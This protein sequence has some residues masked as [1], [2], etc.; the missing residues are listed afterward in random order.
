MSQIALTEEERE[1]L[2][3]MLKV[4][5]GALDVEIQHTDHRDFKELLKHRREVLKGLLSKMR[6]QA[7]GTYS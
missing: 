2:N 1:T 5:L 4:D 6:E 7:V 3:H